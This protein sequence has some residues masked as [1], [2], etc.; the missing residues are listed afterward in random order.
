MNLNTLPR[1]Q[2]STHLVGDKVVMAMCKSCS[3]QKSK[4]CKGQ[5]KLHDSPGQKVK[6]VAGNKCSGAKTAREV[7]L[8][9]DT[10]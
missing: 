1:Y 4:F 9:Y 8:L 2:R 7:S 6:L 5:A 10:V 3:C